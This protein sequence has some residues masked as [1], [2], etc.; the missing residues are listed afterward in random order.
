MMENTREIVRINFTSNLIVN[1]EI[2]IEEGDTI[3]LDWPMVMEE[4]LRGLKCDFPHE[5][6]KGLSEIFYNYHHN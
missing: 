2:R 4:S 3:I 1:K 6:L 5:Y